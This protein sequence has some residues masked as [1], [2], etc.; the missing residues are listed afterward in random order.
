MSIE[1]RGGNSSFVRN[2]T[3]FSDSD[4]GCYRKILLRHHKVEKTFSET[5]HNVFK[6]GYF[7]ETWY[8]NNIM[9]GVEHICDYEVEKEILPG[10]TFRGHIDI[11]EKVSETQYKPHELKSV[12]S[13]NVYKKIFD[14]GIPKYDNL[15]QL[16]SYMIAMGSTEGILAYV[17]YR[18]AITYK[19]FGK[20]NWEEIE[21]KL[22]AITPEVRQFHIVF[23]NDGH[24]WIDGHIT[25][26]TV[27]NIIAFWKEA[28]DILI[29][30]LVADVR[31][32]AHD[33]YKTSCDWCELKELCNKYERDGGTTEWF[34]SEAQR[35]FNE[36]AVEINKKG[37]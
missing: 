10:V 29:N 3:L 15:A 37:N 31:P 20:Y 12:T 33:R 27:H 22:L 4:N 6:V 18:E 13:D 9:K 16:C 32:I 2:G 21:A 30:D 34:V 36:L 17:S 19:E 28:S 25:N 14:K 5:T 1:I 23:D 8:S 11:A 7:N 24:I 26:F 35:F